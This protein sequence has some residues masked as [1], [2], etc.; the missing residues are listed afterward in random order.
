MKISV[1]RPIILICFVTWLPPAL[2]DDV[3]KG[4]AGRTDWMHQA[5]W[6]VMYHYS[7]ANFGKF[8]SEEK[9]DNAITN[10]DV[11]GLAKQLDEV[12][13]GYFVITSR[14][15][16]LPAA[17][18]S[19]F[20]DGKYPTRDLIADLSNALGKYNIKLMLYYPTGMGVD[21]PKSY[22]RAAAEIREL[23][24]RYAKKV[25]GWWLDNNTGIPE[26]QKEIAAAARAG[27]PT[28][29]LAFSPGRGVR[30][31]TTYDDYTAG[32]T[33]APRSVNCR[34]RLVSGA[35][36]HM[37][38]YM[39][40]NWG[41]IHRRREQPRFAVDTVVQITKSV[42]DNGGVVTWDTPFSKETGRIAQQCWGH[43]KAIGNAAG[44]LKHQQ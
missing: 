8:G 41:G 23:S 7:Q 22:R 38:T 27:N 30:R 11:Q 5:K 35:Q 43:L 37:L 14:H 39:A 42:T 1:R 18:F 28:A 20:K 25:S 32:N 2:A 21:P 34:G 26:A 9:W 24:E 31:N 16:G 17:Q 36:W 29:I 13:A 3:L 6:G 19:S 33:H 12:G 40:H 10:F 44:T 15:M 4:D